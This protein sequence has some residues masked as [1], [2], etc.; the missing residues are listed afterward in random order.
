[1]T[2]VIEFPAPRIRKPSRAQGRDAE[3]IIFPGVRIERLEF[4]LAERIKPV[5]RSASRPRGYLEREQA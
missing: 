5:Q 4:D 3:V 1:M 2:A